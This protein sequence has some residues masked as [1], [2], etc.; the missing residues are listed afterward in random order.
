MT[1]KTFL[2]VYFL[3]LLVIFMPVAVFLRPF[4]F[5]QTCVHTVDLAEMVADIEDF[6]D[7]MVRT[8]GTV[9]FY[10][11]A[12]VNEDF[13]LVADEQA[14]RAIPVVVSSAGLSVPFENASVEVVG[15]V[16]NDEVEEGCPYLNASSWIDLDDVVTGTGTIRFLKLE[17]G[18]Y[19]IV[20]DDGEQY[21]PVN[22]N[23]EF[24]VDGLRVRFEAAV[25]HDVLTFHMWGTLVSIRTIERL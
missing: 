2:L 20:G 17:G 9:K 22:L 21:D 25:M 23:A 3:V 12:D 4:E 13:W 16:E 7:E 24:Q 19:G 8:N 6:S 1:L 15:T 18:F 14:V 11:S 10:D 5:D